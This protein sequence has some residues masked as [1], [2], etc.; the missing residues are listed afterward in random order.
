MC[1]IDRIVSRVVREAQVQCIAKLHLM[2][3]VEF[4]EEIKA[5]F[6]CLK[7]LEA[8]GHRHQQHHLPSCGVDSPSGFKGQ[9]GSV[10][11]VIRGVFGFKVFR[12]SQPA[13]V[14]LF[15]YSGRRLIGCIWL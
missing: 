7:H 11:L 5:S 9:D 1:T 10:N 12:T 15:V 3:M 4:L 13:G 2:M 6:I 14:V 8:G